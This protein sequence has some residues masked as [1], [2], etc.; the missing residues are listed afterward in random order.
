M[1]I[2]EDTYILLKTDWIGCF[3]SLAFGYEHLNLAH[4]LYA[5]NLNLYLNSANY[6]LSN[7]FQTFFGGI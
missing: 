5:K 2:L 1:T 3:G 7:G 4:I 6:G